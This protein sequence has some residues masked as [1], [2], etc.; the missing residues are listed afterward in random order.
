MLCKRYPHG[1]DSDRAWPLN[2]GL[3]SCIDS[4]HAPVTGIETMVGPTIATVP[5]LVHIDEEAEISNVLREVQQQA[6]DM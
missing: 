3:Q 5:V 6:V 1:R 4:R 2:F